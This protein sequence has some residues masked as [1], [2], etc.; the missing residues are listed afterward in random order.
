MRQKALLD[1]PICEIRIVNPRTRKKK[2]F[3]AVVSSIET[4]GLKKPITVAKRAAAEDGTQYDLICGQGRIE[5]FL[6]LGQQTIPANVVEASREDQFVMSLV[7]NI[8]RH[9]SSNKGLLREVMSLKNRGYGTKQIALKLGCDV[10][11]VAALGRLIDRNELALVEAVEARKIPLSIALV[12]ATAEEPDIRAALSQAYES[13]ELRGA[14]LQQAKR[15]IAARGTRVPELGGPPQD[16]GRSGRALVREY[17]RRT[18]E[19]QALVR[20][21][22]NTRDKLLLL[23]SAMKTLLADESFITLLR[24]ENL[25]DIPSELACEG[26]L[27]R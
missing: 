25:Q 12:I 7:E 19:Q 27:I 2:R 13:G 3:A 22:S 10:S 9:Q 18:R 8:A 11:Y 20:R 16:S 17:E 21:A 15:I 24:E 4:V 6:A 14:K 23:K 5:A 26:A 1:I